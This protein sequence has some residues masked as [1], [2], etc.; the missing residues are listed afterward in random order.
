MI[1]SPVWSTPSVLP[2]V[3]LRG[4]NGLELERRRLHR[5]K[6]IFLRG[7]GHGSRR[8]GRVT[9]PVWTVLIK[10]NVRHPSC[11]HKS[12][13]WNIFFSWTRH[14]AW[15]WWVYLKPSATLILL[16]SALSENTPLKNSFW[17]SRLLSTVLFIPAFSVCLSVCLS[18]SLSLSLRAC[19]RARARARIARLIAKRSAISL[20]MAEGVVWTFFSSLL[21]FPNRLHVQ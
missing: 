15:K 16:L 8:E 1:S 21:S 6:A 17:T 19:A 10:V 12:S 4:N 14:S 7:Q 20:N 18:V 13:W 3:N 9:M 2:E 11:E 5:R